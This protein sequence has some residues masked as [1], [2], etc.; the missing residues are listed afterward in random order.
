LPGLHFI[1]ATAVHSYGPLCRFV[2]GTAFSA[3]FLTKHIVK[4]S[5]AC[6][7]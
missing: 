4:K 6:R 5:K 3:R 7:A 1:G 2:S